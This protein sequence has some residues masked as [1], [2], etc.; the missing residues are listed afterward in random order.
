M[1]LR[2]SSYLDSICAASAP[3]FQDLAGAHFDDQ[4]LPYQLPAQ[5]AQSQPFGGGVGRRELTGLGPGAG[6]GQH[7]AF[8]AAGGPDDFGVVLLRRAL[9][10]GHRQGAGHQRGQ[11]EAAAAPGEEAVSGSVF[12]KVG[13]LP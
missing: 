11:R 3:V 9:G 10:A 13:T 1:S 8:P 2:L 6:R 4:V 5:Q 7:T 12:G